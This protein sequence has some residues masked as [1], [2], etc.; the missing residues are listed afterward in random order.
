MDLLLLDHPFA[1]QR[2][3]RWFGEGDGDT[4]PGSGTLSIV[5]DR[6]T[7][8]TNIDQELRTEGG[9]L[10]GSGCNYCASEYV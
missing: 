6:T 3:H 2:V 1:D 5:D 7:G 9:S 4:K 8:R 10:L